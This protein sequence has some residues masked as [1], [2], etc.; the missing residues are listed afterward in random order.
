M[1]ARIYTMTF[2]DAM[3]MDGIFENCSTSGLVLCR[4]KTTSYIT[5]MEQSC[6]QT[7]STKVA[8]LRFVH[9][10]SEV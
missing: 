10:A 4:R 2:F 5:V 6:K 8:R 3:R 9:G 7:V 1:R